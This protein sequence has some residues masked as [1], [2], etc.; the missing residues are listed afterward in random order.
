[1]TPPPPAT[2]PDSEDPDRAA[3]LARRAMFLTTALA[4]L[5]C[6]APGTGPAR[7]PGDAPAV[8]T[9]TEPAEPA[10]PAVAAPQ[11][12]ARPPPRAYADLEKLAPPR[13][14]SDRLPADEK[15]ELTELAAGLATAYARLARAYEATP[16]ACSPD[17]PKCEPTWA[18]VVDDLRVVREAVEDPLC[19]MGGSAGKLQRFAAH[20]RF[21]RAQADAIEAELAAAAKRWRAEGKW[22]AWAQVISPPQPCLKC[23]MPTPRVVPAP[24]SHDTPLAIGFADG[25]AADPDADAVQQLKAA[26]DAEPA[27]KVVLR[28]HADPAEKDPDALALA[29]AQAVQASLVALG[30]QAS[31]LAVKSFGADLPI[32]PLATPEGRALNR[33]VD[34]DRA[35]R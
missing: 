20:Q 30:V 2:P 14:V 29:R 7:T 18:S 16:T 24:Y 34:V 35:T 10:E 13:T 23:A 4:A 26:L 19:G 22:T 15:A 25:A 21:L 31:R 6:T 27:L 3:I 11:D 5:G 17:D 12:S 33:R 8:S 1:M 28:G 32:G 9:P